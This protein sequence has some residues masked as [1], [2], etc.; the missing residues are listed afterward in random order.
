MTDLEEFRQT[1]N[2]TDWSPL[3]A[4]NELPYAIKNVSKRE[5][6]NF[7]VTIQAPLDQSA[8]VRVWST[9]QTTWISSNKWGDLPEL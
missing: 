3:T 8:E 2:R 1:Y 7:D 4:N 5:D 6:G 9:T